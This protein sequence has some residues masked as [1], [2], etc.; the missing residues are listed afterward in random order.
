LRQLT[1][2]VAPRNHYANL[3]ERLRDS[4]P[5]REALAPIDFQAENRLLLAHFSG[6]R[7]PLSICPNRHICHILFILFSTHPVNAYLSF[8]AALYFCCDA[9]SVLHK[10]T[11]RQEINGLPDS[12][13]TV[14][15][16][17]STK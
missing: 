2:K 6:K 7:K 11:D 5:I 12:G 3:K 15:N 13:G 16:A 4:E 10:S 8:S 14:A 17:I 9:K 1:P